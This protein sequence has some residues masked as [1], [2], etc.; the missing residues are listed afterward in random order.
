MLDNFK[1]IRKLADELWYKFWSEGMTNPI[2][3]LEQITYLLF[4]K[5]LEDFDEIRVNKSNFQSLYEI[6]N[7]SI[8]RWSYIV[9]MT[10]KEDRFDLFKNKVFPFLK[11]LNNYEVPFAKHL[12][13]AAFNIPSPGLLDDGIKMIVQIFNLIKISLNR[14]K[15]SFTEIQGEFYEYLLNKVISSG[16]SGQFYTPPVITKL[17]VEL[18][19][20]QFGQRIIDPICGS[21]GFLL[22]SYKYIRSQLKEDNLLIEYDRK[23]QSSIY[24][25]DIDP[26]VL[27]L[28]VMNLIM[29]GIYN[30]EIEYKETL[31]HSYTAENR[32]DIVVT[33]PPFGGHIDKSIINPTL[34]LNTSKKDLLF[35]KL[36]SRVLVKDG[37]AAI[38]IPQGVLFRTTSP[39][40]EARKIMIEE[41][42]LKAVISLPG[43]AFYPYT[44]IKTAILIFTKGRK[45][46][47]VWFYELTPDENSYN[48]RG[49]KIESLSEINDILTHYKARHK[50]PNND[51]TR[52]HFYVPIAEIIKEEYNLTIERYKEEVLDEEEHEAPG[53]IIEKLE[54]I[55][56][57]IT[58]KVN[59]MKVL[60]K[61]LGLK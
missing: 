28:C 56:S 51:R 1:D 27:R 3:A 30:P 7:K 26:L 23:L 14:E 54:S 13:Q 21:G 49:K 59:E 37:T 55:E 34:E 15:K 46:E 38:V 5:K 60:F 36:I 4:I 48:Q 31:G 33:N 52:N 19:N 11:K 45:T 16:R 6:D 39:D 17:M 8:L 57:E 18:I 35:I 41:S 9:K 47:Q 53:I 32:Y 12:E 43:G 20:P 42:E 2:T 10:S 24:G 29:H 44:G 25:Y 58:T 40:L 50:E 61:D 22:E